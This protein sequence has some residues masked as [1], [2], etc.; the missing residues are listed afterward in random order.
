M[1][2]S[3]KSI[4]TIKLI[5]M[6]SLLGLFISC[7]EE[8]EIIEG[9]DKRTAISAS[10][11][12]VD[13]IRKVT[14]KDGSFDNIIDD[15]SEISIEYPYSIKIRNENI[16]ITSLEDIEALKKEYFPLKNPI[17]I[18]YP[19]TISFSDYSEMTLNNPGQLQKIQNQFNTIVDDDDIECIDFIY[20]LE[21]NLYDTEFQK[22]DLIFP[23]NDKDLHIILMDIEDLIIEIAYPIE[24][25]LSEGARIIINNNGELEK[26]IINA[27]DSCDEQDEIEFNYKKNIN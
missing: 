11:N 6:I 4:Y 9:P 21:I 22:P 10:D 13:L 12:L 1:I 8:Y 24:V 7:Q 19:V 25:E 2:I 15:C 14:L 5:M 3:Q 23:E 17:L 16:S 26:E 20:P 27:M 18:E